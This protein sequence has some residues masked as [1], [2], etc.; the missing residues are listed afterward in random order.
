MI[1]QFYLEN[2]IWNIDGVGE[3]EIKFNIKE[4]FEMCCG[5]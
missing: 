4:M 1:I 2:T 3:I 5:R